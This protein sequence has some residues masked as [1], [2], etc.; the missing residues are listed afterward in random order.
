LLSAVPIDRAHGEE[1]GVDRLAE[2]EKQLFWFV[3]R[4]AHE[5]PMNKLGVGESD[6]R[7]SEERQG[8]GDRQRPE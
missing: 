4:P 2:A 5:L 1:P 8:D 7:E 3:H 6:C